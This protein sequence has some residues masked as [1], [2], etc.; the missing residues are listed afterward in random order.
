MVVIGANTME[1]QANIKTEINAQI[2]VVRP[3]ETPRESETLSA[4][5]TDY[6]FGNSSHV[7][8]PHGSVIEMISL[9]DSD[10][11][12]EESEALTES[13]GESENDLESQVSGR[14]VT[15]FGVV[16]AIF[17]IAIIF[18]TFGLA[19]AYAV[20]KEGHY[21]PINHLQNLTDQDQ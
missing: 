17:L 20:G 5:S 3:N 9:D 10:S 12:S 21:Q 1:N 15:V 4:E 14:C 18:I 6:H 7:S 13:W 19:L 2:D 16:L 11:E 8:S